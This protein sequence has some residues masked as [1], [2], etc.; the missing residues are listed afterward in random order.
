MSRSSLQNILN[1]PD[2]FQTW[3]F[4]LFFPSIPGVADP[5]QLSYKCQTSNLPGFNIES[6]PIEL[7]GVKKQEAGRATYQHTFQCQFLEV[8]DLSTR[9]AMRAWRESMRSWKLNTGSNS[10]VYKVNGQ[11]VLYDNTPS[12]IGT[13]IVYGMYPETV[14][15]MSLEGNASTAGMLSVTFSYD[16]TDE[17]T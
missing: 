8:V 14:D 1:L 6:V 10:G 16:Y 12:V 5:I 3:N 11:I 9:R 7:H 2:A 13:M 4:D 17:T 15:D